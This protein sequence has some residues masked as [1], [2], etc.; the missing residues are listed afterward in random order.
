VDV[1]RLGGLRWFGGRLGELCDEIGEVE[2][3]ILVDLDADVRLGSVDFFED[4]WFAEER[5]E[6]EIGVGFTEREEWFA[7]SVF[8]EQAADGAGEGVGID[9][10]LA[11]GDFA[12]EL[13]GKLLD[14][15]VLDDEGEDKKA[16][17]GV[18]K[19]EPDRPEDEFAAA[20]GNGFPVCRDA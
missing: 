4:P 18:K 16:E 8:D 17:D 6:L 2:G 5:G 13:L 12:V 3:V 9:A 10:D 15:D 11:D 14:G 1:E 19:D 20:R 7:V